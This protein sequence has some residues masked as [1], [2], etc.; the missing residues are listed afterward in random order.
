MGLEED[1]LNVGDPIIVT[2]PNEYENMTGEIVEFSPSGK[3]V[4]VQ[5]YNGDEASMHVSDVEYNEYADEQDV[6]DAWNDDEPMEIPVDEDPNQTPAGGE[7][8]STLSDP[9][10][11]EESAPVK[12]VNVELDEMGGSVLVEIHGDERQGFC[13][14]RAGK[15]MPTKFKTLEEVEMALEMFN[16]RRKA[17]V[18][19]EQSADYIDEA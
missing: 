1:K 5:M 7:A 4:V 18:E 15:E 12:T 14:K 10:Y 9:T 8:V 6:D 16:A 17:Q 11:A 13:I 19:A 2:A 3:F